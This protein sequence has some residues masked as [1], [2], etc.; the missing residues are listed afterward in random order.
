MPTCI[1]RWSMR[2]V[3]SVVYLDSAFHEDFIFTLLRFRLN[4]YLVLASMR[5]LTDSKTMKDC[6]HSDFQNA[7][8]SWADETD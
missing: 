4:Y 2:V 3:F 1:A 5:M 7:I 6:S 8:V